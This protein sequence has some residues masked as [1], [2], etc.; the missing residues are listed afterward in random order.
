M[1]KTTPNICKKL[2]V[3]T[4]QCN[5]CSQFESDLNK[6]REDF[7]ECC[8]NVTTELEEHDE[9]ITNNTNDIA[10]LDTNISHQIGDMDKRLSDGLSDVVKQSEKGA[11]NGVAPLDSNG[12]IPSNYFDGG[13]G[14]GG[15]STELSIDQIYPVGSLMFLM[16]GVDPN[17][18]FEN[19][20][21]VKV[22][23]KYILASDSSHAVGTTGGQNSVSY[24]PRGTNANTKLTAAQSGVPA[25]NHGM[26][27]AHPLG[28]NADG[29]TMRYLGTA[30]YE[31]RSTMVNYTAGGI[32]HA[33]LAEAPNMYARYSSPPSNKT[34]TDNNTAKNA[35]SGHTH[36]F[37]GTAAT[38]QTMPSYISVNVWQRTA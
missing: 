3:S 6:L 8:D 1:A 27:H 22:E 23:G 20:T 33:P 36:T 30:A 37:T 7:E 13:G 24:T 17:T 26:A 11:P 31:T 28:T 19:T 4:F 2:G 12:K 16:N 21:W 10:Q 9:R 15:S 35:T 5:D 14:G 34:T 38:I 29:R 32:G 25:H 18:L